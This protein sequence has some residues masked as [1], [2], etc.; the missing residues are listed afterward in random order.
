MFSVTIALVILALCV[1]YYYVKSVYF[2]LRGPIPG[3]SPQFFFGNLIQ[4]GLLFSWKTPSMP[5]VLI[6]L[7]KK[8]G[9]VYQLWFGATRLIMINSLE[10]AQH[11]FTHRNIY[12]QGDMFTKNLKILNPK[13]VICLKGH[14]ISTRNDRGKLKLLHFRCRI[15]TTCRIYC[16]SISSWEDSHPSDYHPRLY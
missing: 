2:T 12:D 11:V 5:D 3:I 9:D 16:S 7:T 1:G 14:F 8:F 4:L 15:Q 10:D 13:G 6:N